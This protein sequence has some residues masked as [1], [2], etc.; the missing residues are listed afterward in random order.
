MGVGGVGGQIED[1]EDHTNDKSSK[2]TRRVGRVRRKIE[3]EVPFLFKKRRLQSTGGEI[4]YSEVKKGDRELVRCHGP[5]ELSVRERGAEVIKK[6]SVG[7]GIR[8]RD[9]GSDTIVDVA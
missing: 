7:V 1:S 3:V 6:C 9:P 4:S 2:Q 5:G 8:M